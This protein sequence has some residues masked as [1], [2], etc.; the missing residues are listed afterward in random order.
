MSDLGNFKSYFTPEMAQAQAQGVAN[1]NHILD[2]F[3]QMGVTVSKLAAEQEQNAA[4]RDYQKQKLQ[5]DRENLMQD[6]AQKD[7]QYLLDY[8]KTI[9]EADA[10][11]ANAAFKQQA[12]QIALNKESRA[13]LDWSDKKQRAA[14]A[15]QPENAQAYAKAFTSG[16]LDGL[17][18]QQLSALESKDYI[19]LMKAS[20]TSA[21]TN[22]DKENINTFYDRYAPDIINID[23]QLHVDPTTGKSNAPDLYKPV[24]DKIKDD[25]NNGRID[26]ATASK[27]LAILYARTAKQQSMIKGNSASTAA[28][29]PVF[30]A[31]DLDA[32]G[33]PINQRSYLT[34]TPEGLA[35]LQKDQINI[36]TNPSAGKV[37]TKNTFN[38]NGAVTGT[39][40]IKP[41]K[42]K[43]KSIFDE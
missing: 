17:T 5:L 2:Q 34:N 43:K 8:Q 21:K 31:A 36:I 23:S 29:P 4:Q 11:K 25:M 7:R 26:R 3:G 10:H 18:S 19:S 38:K 9:N 24:L 1:H 6:K 42:A 15:Q 12:A 30:G 32:N 22:R 20:A 27:Q 37:I 16:K 35:Q 40:V 13:N 14:F 28:P 33:N 39:Q 41:P